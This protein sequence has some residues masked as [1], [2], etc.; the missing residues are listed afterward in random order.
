MVRARRLRSFSLVALQLALALILTAAGGAR[1]AGTSVTELV[2]RADHVLRGKTTAALVKMHIHKR[3]YDRTYDMVY[4]GDERGSHDRALIKVLGPARWRGRGTLKVEG[5][6]S[7]YDPRTDRVTVLSSSMLGDSWMGSHFT[8][9][10]LVKE[11]DLAKDYRSSLLGESKKSVGGKPAHF[12]RIRLT[13]TPQAPVAWNHIVVELYQQDGHVIP[14]KEA[15][16]RRGN[17]KAAT[18]TLTFSNVRA[19]GGRIAPTRLT[20]RVADEPGEYTQLD[21]EKARFDV[22]VPSTK[23]TE[24]ALRD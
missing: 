3:A 19:I 14:V 17:Q 6:L 10:D 15:Y 24:Q 1:A 12:Y 8:N 11:T 21:Y 2:H 13:P 16:Y 4:W 7:V 9:D 22:D 23:F 20:M 18:R 5:R